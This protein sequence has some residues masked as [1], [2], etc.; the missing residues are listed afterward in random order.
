MEL[1]NAFNRHVFST[2]N[3]NPYDNFF[4]VPTGTIDG[5]RHMQLTARIEF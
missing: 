5:P 4:G 2:P 3:L 1:L